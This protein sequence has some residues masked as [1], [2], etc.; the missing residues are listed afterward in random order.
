MIRS[1]CNT[2]PVIWSYRFKI[3]CR[4]LNLWKFSTFSVLWILHL[5]N[6]NMFLVFLLSI[7]LTLVPLMLFHILLNDSRFLARA[8]M[9]LTL[10]TQCISSVA[11]QLRSSPLPPGW[12]REQK[13]CWIKIMW[14]LYN[15]I[16]STA[17]LF[18]PYIN[19]HMCVCVCVLGNI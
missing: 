15:I 1:Y 3:N 14:D 7:T 12:A 19:V 16:R 17:W 9:K 8:H 13:H 6:M 5:I 11:Q 4:F 10:R 2:F 18:S